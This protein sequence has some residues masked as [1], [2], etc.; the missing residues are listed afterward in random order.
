M[1]HVIGAI[2]A[3]VIILFLGYLF[4]GQIANR[5]GRMSVESAATK[6]L[7]VPTTVEHAS[8]GLFT[9]RIVFDGVVIANPEG[10]KT[11][12][13]FA[14][15]ERMEVTF[16]PSS[17]FGSTFEIDDLL[18]DDVTIYWVRGFATGN[19]GTIVD[20]VEREGKA[21]PEDEQRPVRVET[22]RIENVVCH[23]QLNPIS[24]EDTVASVTI[25]EINVEG[26]TRDNALGMLTEDVARQLLTA[27]VARVAEEAPAE[28]P[29]QLKVALHRGLDGL[30]KTVGTDVV[31]KLKKGTASVDG[32]L[33][34]FEGAVNKLLPPPPGGETPTDP[35]LPNIAKQ[36]FSKSS[37]QGEA[38][39]APTAPNRR[40]APTR[41]DVERKKA[42]LP[43][44]PGLPGIPKQ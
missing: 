30:V 6:A 23:L 9:G 12:P 15:I 32:I 34:R 36:F 2:A 29:D 19:L 41:R 42:R 10:Y 3:I 22:A 31:G 16:R 17:F 35:S 14:R 44:P 7:G 37:S 13:Y 43:F 21:N 33:G 8:I 27:V 40:R 20:Y 24:P 1:K 25:P 39:K 26:L 4:G 18:M 11:A 5:V 38:D 28:I